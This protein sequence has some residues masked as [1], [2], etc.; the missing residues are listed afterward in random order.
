MTPNNFL[1]AGQQYDPVTRQYYLRARYYNP[2]IACFTQED[3][4][5]GDGLNLYAYCRNN[6]VC[7]VDPS[8]HDKETYHNY[9][10]ENTYGQ[11]NVQEW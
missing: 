7:H 6:P 1:Y 3:I 2:V 10:G 4:Y 9:A 11:C 5:R 8:G